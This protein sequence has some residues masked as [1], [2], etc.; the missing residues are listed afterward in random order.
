MLI[1]GPDE[2]AGK[3]RRLPGRDGGAPGRSGC[4]RAPPVDVPYDIPDYLA[5][6]AET[7]SQALTDLGQSGAIKLMD[8]R[9]VRTVDRG[10]LEQ[11][12]GA[13]VAA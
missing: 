6:S 1:P 5:L 2:R 10:A 7:G 13:G 12:C 3:G 8:T 11:A 9:R 4:R